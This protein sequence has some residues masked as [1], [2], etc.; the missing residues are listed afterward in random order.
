MTLI[1]EDYLETHYMVVATIESFLAS[2]NP[3]GVKQLYMSGGI[4]AMWTFAKKVTDD[5]EY[6]HR[7]TDWVELPWMETLEY[8]IENEVKKLP[9]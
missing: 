6:A 1:N 8:Y 5:F 4:G 9:Q 3:N 7:D 2:D